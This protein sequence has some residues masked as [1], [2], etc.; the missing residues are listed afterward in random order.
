MGRGCIFLRQF[1]A[2]RSLRIFIAHRDI[3]F[4]TGNGL[5]AGL[6]S[7]LDS[8]GIARGDDPCRRSHGNAAVARKWSESAAHGLSRGLHHFW[9]LA[10]EEPHCRSGADGRAHR[11]IETVPLGK[12][13]FGVD[14]LEGDRLEASLTENPAYAS[15]V[16]KRE[17]SR[18]LGIRFQ[19]RREHGKDRADRHA[20][21][22]ILV[23]RP[24][25]CKREAS[26]GAERTADIREAFCRF[27]EEHDAHAGYPKIER[28][29]RKGIRGGIGL[30]ERESRVI[31]QSLA[32]SRQ[33][34]LRYIDC[35]YPTID[36]DEAQ[37]ASRGNAGPAP[38]ID[39]ALAGLYR[40][41]RKERVV[42]G[43]E[44]FLGLL[45]RHPGTA[46]RAI[47]VVAHARVR[48][49]CSDDGH[50]PNILAAATR[51]NGADQGPGCLPT[52]GDREE[53]HER[54][55]AIAAT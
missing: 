22:R 54:G 3:A 46:A 19:L 36:A 10:A 26:T 14:P 23:E 15:F 18:L 31:A 41:T 7:L 42:N 34:R 28:R 17:A 1:G 5:V 44:P 21:P 53:A 11:V 6:L 50:A 12:V 16:A 52:L 35:E 25:T 27:G 38:D 8:S 20:L 33:H 43:G 13:A 48:R 9:W 40:S 47:P 45:T 51:G 37:E 24:P 4:G 55:E 30:Y 2:R 49:V 32:R 39:N 29:F